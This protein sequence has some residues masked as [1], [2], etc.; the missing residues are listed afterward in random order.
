VRSNA[1][2]Q[3]LCVWSGP[4]MV[5]TFVTAFLVMGFIPPPSPKLSGPE[6]VTLFTRDQDRIRAGG[7]LMV[8][9]SAF[10]FP[11]VSVISVQ[12]R[13]IEG[14]HAPMATTQLGSGALGAFLFLTPMIVLEAMAFKPEHLNPDVASTMYYLA[15]LFFIGTP[16]FAVIQNL[17]IA[18]A[19]LQ[20]FSQKPVFP[21]WAGYFNLWIGLLFLPGTMCFFF[22][23]GPFAW[24]GLFPWWLPLSC[25][26]IWMAV[27]ATLLLQ[28]IAIQQAADGPEV[29]AD[30]ADLLVH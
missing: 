2:S 29:T 18:V 8:L 24:R 19:I 20:D 12:L 16:V 9:G 17:S 14:K 3:R 5:V 7:V 28:A 6:I 23:S 13:R 21:R 30:A 22:D 1:F 4:A 10:L 15:W 25:F 11:W 27:M 26:G